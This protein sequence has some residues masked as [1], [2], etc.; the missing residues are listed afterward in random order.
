MSLDF[1]FHR[2]R[3]SFP[4]PVFGLAAAIGWTALII[5]YFFDGNSFTALLTF[6]FNVP[7][8]DYFALGIMISSFLVF[9]MNI[10][11][12]SLIRADFRFVLNILSF[13]M[14]AS[15]FAVGYTAADSSFSSLVTIALL[16]FI[17]YRL[18]AL[19]YLFLQQR[20]ASGYRSITVIVVSSAS[21]L[22]A[23]FLIYR[24]Y[25][26]GATQMLESS[27]ALDLTAKGLLLGLTI[28][29]IYINSIY[30]IYINRKVRQ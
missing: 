4:F 20:G 24:I 30:M 14:F 22:P 10:G 19:L 3:R 25:L 5:Y 18:L 6:S 28:L 16:A 27:N 15:C 26:S 1:S 21:I 11:V 9:M 17:V 23:A 12:I 8:R 2:R 13:A 29:T 7:V